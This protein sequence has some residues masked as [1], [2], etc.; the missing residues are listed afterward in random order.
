MRPWDTA[1]NSAAIFITLAGLI[2]HY[3]EIHAEGAKP[4]IDSLLPIR[5]NS[6]RKLNIWQLP[7]DRIHIGEAYKPSM[8]MLP[9]GELLMV[10][11]FQEQKPMGKVREWTGIWRS[12]DGGLTWSEREEVKDMI[13][14]E[15]WLTC[16]KDGTLFATCHLLA[17]D[18]NNNSGYAHSYLHRSTD[19]GKTWRRMRIGPDGFPARAVT[20]CSRNVVERPDGT[21]LLGVGVNEMEMG[22]LAWIWTSHDGGMTWQK[23]DPK[24]KIGTYQNRPYNNYDAFFAEDFTFLTKSGRLLHFVRCGPPSP[25]Y[26]MNDGRAVPQ[27]DDGIDRMLRCESTDGGLSWS[28]LRDNGDYGMHYPRVIRLKDGRLLMTFTQRSTI[29]PI[30]LQAVFSHDDGETWDFNNDRI[31]IEGRTPWGM[32]QGGGFG[33]TIELPDGRLISC[34]T[35][36]GLDNKT[37]LEVVH[38]RMPRSASPGK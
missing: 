22:R 8:A 21:L 9:N 33:N 31:I 28:D 1:K 35:F 25:M 3:D 38:W 2:G 4:K 6:P 27:G 13:G 12:S 36:R 14:R 5:I 37:F 10:A 34:Y 18:I 19:G 26:P 30:G 24:V 15:Q 11:L 29:Y 32:P 23:T 7:A 17:N 20:M 16:T